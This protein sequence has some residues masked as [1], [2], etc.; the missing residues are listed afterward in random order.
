[1]T[2]IIDGTNK[3]LGRLAT[4]VVDLLKKGYPVVVINA[5]APLAQNAGGYCKKGH[6]GNDTQER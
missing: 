3:P 1:M 6:K 5:N 4:F 2:I